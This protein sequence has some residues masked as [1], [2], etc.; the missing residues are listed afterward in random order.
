MYMKF[1]LRKNLC[2]AI[3][4]PKSP[5]P[6]VGAYGGFPL[7]GVPKN[8]GGNSCVDTAL[9]IFQII[10]EYNNIFISIVSQ[11]VDQ[12]I[13]NIAILPL[14]IIFSGFFKYFYSKFSIKTD[15]ISLSH[16]KKIYTKQSLLQ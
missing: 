2:T 8:D 15:K 3:W 14:T 9:F 13:L 6:S 12:L 11:L 16:R 7:V 1:F 10:S 5:S 4:P